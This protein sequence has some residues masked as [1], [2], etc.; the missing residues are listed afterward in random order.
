MALSTPWFDAHLD[1]A[2]LAVA[3]RDMLGTPEA[4]STPDNRAGLTIPSLIEGNVR[5]I[6][7]TIFTAPGDNGPEGYPIGDAERAHIVGRAQLEAYLTWRDR[8]LM[9]L[10]RFTPLRSMRGLSETRGGM[11]VA[12][13]VPLGVSTK[14]ARL[15]KSPPIHVGILM[16]NADPIRSPQEVSW[17]KERGLVAVGLCWATPSRYATGNRAAPRDGGLTPIGRELVRE[18]DRFGILHDAS[19]LSDA[20]FADLCDTTQKMIIA[21]HSNCRA[22]SDPSGT[23]QRH[24]T[25]A[26]IREIVRRDGVVGINLF[27][28]FLRPSCGKGE[29]ATIDEVVAHIE[30][31]CDLAS[32]HAHIGLGSDMDGGFPA[33]QMP[34]GIDTPS[35]YAR[36]AEALSARNWTDAQV[37][38]F[39]AGNWMRV[40]G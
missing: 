13:H 20:S 1:L 22:I 28:L 16:E 26:Q 25:D 19:H 36:I 12:N 8:G 14:F 15:P 40:F 39:C 9:Q 2:M 5:L 10:D 35:G 17:W 11:G 37:M 27:S 32:S 21:S 7:G 29:R 3:G 24:L 31:I 30:H 34:A 6:L 38:D 23:N 18:L 33:D 4:A